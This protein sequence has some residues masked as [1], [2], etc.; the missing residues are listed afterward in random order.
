[1]PFLLVISSSQYFWNP[2]GEAAGWPEARPTLVLQS[3]ATS[4]FTWDIQGIVMSAL[5]H[6]LHSTDNKY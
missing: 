5:L 6:Y 4:Y 1:M 3:K 2:D